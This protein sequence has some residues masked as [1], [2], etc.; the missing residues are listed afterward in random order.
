MPFTWVDWAIVAIVAISALISLSRGFVKEALSLLTWI[1]AGVVAWMFGGS[2]SVYLAGYIETPSAR[3]IAGCAI[4][5]IATLLVGAMVNY[6][7][8]ELI[9]VT[10]LSGTDRFLGMAF[11]AAR[12]ALLVVVAVGLL[13]LGPVQQDAWWQESVLVPKF[14]LVA[15]WSKNLILGW[16]SQWLASGISVPADLPFKEHL[17]PAKT[18]Q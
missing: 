14:L 12:G 8:G 5:F 13:S 16:S 3:V 17:L 4:M 15:D 1:I 9:R 18:P 6:L 2:L 10:G 7:I 11:G